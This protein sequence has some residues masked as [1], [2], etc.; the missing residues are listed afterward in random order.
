VSDS[1]PNRRRSTLLI[2]FSVV[3]VDLIGFGIVV[4]V[5]P[6]YAREYGA[7]ATTLGFLVSWSWPTPPPSSCALR[8]GGGSRIALDGG[9]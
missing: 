2:L 1:I 5:L 8:C 6:F 9:R 3:V 4:P 7:S